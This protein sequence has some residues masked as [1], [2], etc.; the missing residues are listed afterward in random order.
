[1]KHAAYF[2]DIL[3]DT[4]KVVDKKLRRDIDKFNDLHHAVHTLLITPRGELVLGSIPVREDLPNFYPRKLGSTVATIR[5]SGETAEQAA[6]RSLSRELFIQDGDIRLIGE[7][8]FQLPERKN[9][10]TAYYIVADP[11]PQ[12]SVIDIDT[13]SVATTHQFRDML[14]HNAGEIAPTMKAIW[15]AFAHKLPI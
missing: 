10:I 9:Y 14:E 15:Q 11:P 13:L 12:F 7:K 2:V 3:D 4:G 8:M 6:L 1:M 5:R